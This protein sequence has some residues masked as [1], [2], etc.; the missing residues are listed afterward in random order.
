MAKTF[1]FGS[2]PRP[3]ARAGNAGAT[4]A[5]SG[6][7]KT[8]AAGT[9]GAAPGKPAPP[10]SQRGRPED[11]PYKLTISLF[12]ANLFNHTNKGTPI[13]NLTS[14]LFGMSN[15][16]SANSSFTFGASSAQSNRSVSLRA[17]FNF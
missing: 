14:P 11:K 12:V 9:G 17:Q 10:A 5:G 8:G 4:G 16:L 2:Q 7:A 15:A 1:G 13:G 6:A 3:P